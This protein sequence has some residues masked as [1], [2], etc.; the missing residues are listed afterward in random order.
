MAKHLP[1]CNVCQFRVFRNS[2]DEG[3]FV[4]DQ[5]CCILQ[6]WT[7]SSFALRIAVLGSQTTEQ[8]SMMGSTRA[9]YNNFKS[10]CAAG[11]RTIRV[12]KHAHAR[13]VRGDLGIWSI[14]PDSPAAEKFC[15]L[16][17][18]RL[19]LKP[20]LAQSGTTV[21]IVICASS[22]VWL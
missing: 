12:R 11:G 10:L 3:W 1:S 6:F 15:K 18:L 17:A 14:F 4:K 8:Y 22:Q 7:L 21:T 9:V 5:A 13:G 16:D 2:S 19:L 20:L